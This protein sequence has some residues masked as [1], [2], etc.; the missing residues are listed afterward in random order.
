M[1]GWMERLIRRDDDEPHSHAR[2]HDDEKQQFL[3]RER[4]IEARLE[5]L[6]LQAEVIARRAI[7][8]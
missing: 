3:A 1:I 4:E 2:D 5:R 8:E 6:R 7:D